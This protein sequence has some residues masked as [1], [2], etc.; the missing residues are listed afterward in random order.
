MGKSMIT[1]FDERQRNHEP[2]GFIVSGKRQPSPERP[3]RID[4]LLEGVKRLGGP[5]IAP[6]AIADETL[7]HI[8]DARYLDFMATL[9]E[10]WQRIPD[11]SEHQGP[12]DLRRRLLDAMS[13]GSPSR[14]EGAVRRYY[15][16]LLR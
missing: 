15:E 1:V 16:E 13:E 9:A 10:R 4:M 8:H 14:Y 6:P 12:D 2:P 7:G 5:I 11:A 3:E